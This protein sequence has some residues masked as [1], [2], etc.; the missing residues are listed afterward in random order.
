MDIDRY[1]DVNVLGG[2]LTDHGLAK[3]SYEYTAPTF[4]GHV[5]HLSA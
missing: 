2:R 4:H 3:S 5:A 1:D